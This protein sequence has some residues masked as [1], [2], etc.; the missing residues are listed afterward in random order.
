MC[1]SQKTSHCNRSR[2][3]NDDDVYYP[4]ESRSP[5]AC[6]QTHGHPHHGDPMPKRQKNVARNVGGAATEDSPPHLATWQRSSST[7]LWFSRRRA[8]CACGAA[9]LAST[10]WPSRRLE[11]GLT[12][13]SAGLMLGRCIWE[14]SSEGVAHTAQGAA[15]LA[16]TRW[17]SCRLVSGSTNCSAGSTLGCCLDA[18]A[19]ARGIP[20]RRPTQRRW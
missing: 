12:H 2:S 13:G 4:Q 8:Y 1:T 7:S 6:A 16:A 3:P 18:W 14:V 11:S 20:P 9:Q 10:L 17:P 19:R 15:L 5:R